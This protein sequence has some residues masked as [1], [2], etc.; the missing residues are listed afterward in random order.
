MIHQRVVIHVG[1]A[2]RQKQPVQQRLAVL[3]IRGNGEVVADDFAAERK[4][5]GAEAAVAILPDMYGRYGTYGRGV[6]LNLEQVDLC[7]PSDA[8]FR[9]G[10][11]EGAIGGTRVAGRHQRKT[12]TLVCDNEGSRLEEG[13]GGNMHDVDGTL[14]TDRRR[15]VDEC[16]VLQRRRVEGDKGE[17]VHSG[18]ARQMVQHNGFV[19]ARGVGQASEDHATGQR[20]YL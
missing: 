9:D 18:M 2:T 8:Y 15:N 4:C 1:F 11:S 3:R 10:V 16:A 5:M 20:A 7:A 19:R 6:G 13:S 12:G 17:V 14:K